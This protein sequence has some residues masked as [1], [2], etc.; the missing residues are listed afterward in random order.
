MAFATDDDQGLLE[1]SIERFIHDAYS[2]GRWREVLR[3]PDGFSRRHWATL[4][5]MGLLALPFE[6]GDGG[7]GG[8]LSDVAMLMKQM[9]RGLAMEPYLQC[10]VIAGR[11][12]A[13]AAITPTR[14]HWLSN[15][16]S[17]ERLIGLAHLE[18]GTHAGTTV[19]ST[20]LRHGPQG[21]RLNGAKMLVPVARALDALLVTATDEKNRLQVCAI[22]AGLAGIAIRDYLTVEGRL[23]GDV[24]FRDVEIEAGMLLDFVDARSTLQ[25][26][27]TFACAASCAES[28]GC[29]QVLLEMTVEYGKSRKQFGQPIGNF[30]VLKHRLVDCHSSLEQAQAMLTLACCESSPTW[31]VNVAAAKAFID[32]HATRLGHEAIQ[33]HGGMG[34]TDELAVSHYHKRIVANSLQHGDRYL[35]TDL[36]VE[37]SMFSDPRSRSSALTY[38]DLLSPQ[39]D[40][41]K[42]EVQEFLS[43]ALTNALRMA[44]RRQTCTFPE[45]DV[46]ITWQRLLHEKGWL[47]PHWPVNLGG[48]GW[49]GVERFLFEYE[50][51]IAGAPERV[52]MGFRYV[53]PVIARFGSEWQKSYFLPKLLTSEHYWAQG[54]SEP[55]AGSDLAAL[56]TTAVRRGDHYVVNGTKMW[57][58]HAHYADWLFCIVKTE[59]CVRPQDGISFLLIDLASPGVR[60]E[61]IRL[62]AV[63]H[64]V[65][66]VFLDDVRVPECNLVGEPGRGWQYAKFLLELERGGNAFCGRVRYEFSAVKELVSRTVPELWR[67]RAFMH[68][69][70]ALEYRLM[71]LEMLEFQLARSTQQSKESCVGGSLTKLVASELQ[72]DITELGMQAA[73]LGGLEFEHTRPLPDSDATGFPGIDLELVAMPR[74]LN[75]RVA[76]IFGGSSEI[77]REIIAKQLFGLR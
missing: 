35:Q 13:Q 67:D 64:E 37:K 29:M 8:S 77:Q 12:L 55:G 31:S 5:D 16:V 52:P 62:L 22:P 45:K 69:L 18:R 63:D 27:L 6:E 43:P 42:R 44:V 49:T 51:A 39:E 3:E 25:S 75:T 9:G 59:L 53:G 36:F 74:Y 47:A 28:V 41:F 66:Q 1:Q 73:G 33:M 65:N 20:G 32:E 7:L 26:V 58:T 56:K 50:C 21:Y 23:V 71:A 24:T 60:I 61:P 17:G 48:T 14:A 40:A 15:L 10:V 70:A 54:F 46:T 4:A 34:L 19:C 68:R 11:L 38:A 2:V 72:K 57:T 76:S 30:Q